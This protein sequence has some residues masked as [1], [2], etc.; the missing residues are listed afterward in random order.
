MP[1]CTQQ[2]DSKRRLIVMPVLIDLFSLRKAPIA[3]AQQLPAPA[4]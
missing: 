4:E 3:V 1:R 2:I